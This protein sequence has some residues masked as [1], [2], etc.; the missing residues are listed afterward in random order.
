ML[1]A[2][3]LS[4]KVSMR[5]R[6]SSLVTSDRRRLFLCLDCLAIS[7]DKDRTK[8]EHEQQNACDYCRDAVAF[9]TNDGNRNDCQ[10]GQGVKS[11][12]REAR[13]P[14]SDKALKIRSRNSAFWSIVLHFMLL[15]VHPADSVWGSHAGMN[16]TSG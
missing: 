14:Q 15:I 11:A 5:F 4:R 8:A 6:T 10:T 3:V 1:S 12:T 13:G 7:L 9:H 16:A 2:S